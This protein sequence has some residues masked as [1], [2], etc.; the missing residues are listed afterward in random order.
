MAKV[1]MNA[2]YTGIWTGKGDFVCQDDSDG[3]GPFLKEWKSKHP[4]PTL[5]RLE[6][7]DKLGKLAR[8]HRIVT[9][10]VK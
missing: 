6:S 1:L 10:G 4:V 3:K 5:A 9:T 2:G 7:W 8:L